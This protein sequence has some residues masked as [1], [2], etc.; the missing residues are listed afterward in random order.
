MST[1]NGPYFRR[2]VK[3]YLAQRIN[4][5]DVRV[6]FA[7]PTDVPSLTKFNA[8]TIRDLGRDGL[9]M[10]MS[11]SFFAKMIAAGLTII[12]EGDRNV[13]GYSIAVPAGQGQPV[14]YPRTTS[15]RIGLLFG[16][17]LDP[18]IRGLGWQRWL[19]DL[20]LAILQEAGF[21]EV[22][23]TVS[24]FNIPSLVNLVDSGFRVV[25]LK[26][27]LDDHLRFILRKCTDDRE[28]VTQCNTPWKIAAL[29]ENLS[30]HKFLLEE[31]G[32]IGMKILRW[33]TLVGNTSAL[34]YSKP[35][36]RNK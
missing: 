30:R 28:L 35:E 10:P 12:L 29:N 23:C 8:N 4:G 21:L 14:F 3:N 13:L 31:E 2:L 1:P 25:A 5:Y 32:Y 33:G 27:L 34:L 26:S 24:P 16:T 22:Q 9:F 11:E 7:E 18:S 20:R 36:Y 17:A 6:R 19:I 15:E